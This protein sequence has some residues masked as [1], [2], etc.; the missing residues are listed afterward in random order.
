MQLTK[1]EFGWSVLL[2]IFLALAI[3]LTVYTIRSTINGLASKTWP[4]TN[5]LILDA[6]W[7]SISRGGGS[8]SRAKWLVVYKYHVG[9]NE[10]R[11]D[12]VFFG[13]IAD[14]TKKEIR[15]RCDRNKVGA[16]VDVYYNPEDP[17]M[18]VLEP[19]VNGWWI[20]PLLTTIVYMFC[21]FVYWSR[22][23]LFFGDGFS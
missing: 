23:Y 22:T 9:A 21:G 15:D 2:I 1:K 8:K 13:V 4:K 3:F 20:M 10:Y 11:S 6:R 7:Q 17:R 5:G 19:G 16:A 14:D 12:R 18:A